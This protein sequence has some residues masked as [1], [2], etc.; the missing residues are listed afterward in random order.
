[1]PIINKLQAGKKKLPKNDKKPFVS[2]EHDD[3]IC[4]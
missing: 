1:M 3:H 2:N 4:A